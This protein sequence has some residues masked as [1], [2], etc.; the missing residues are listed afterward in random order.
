VLE[1]FLFFCLYSFSCIA[2]YS[3]TLKTF[4]T[5]LSLSLDTHFLVSF[6]TSISPAPDPA[7]YRS[8]EI[9]RFTWSSLF[10]AENHLTTSKGVSGHRAEMEKN[11]SRTQNER[12]LFNSSNIMR[13]S[14]MVL[15]AQNVC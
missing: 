14:G 10:D 7:R 3:T 13:D 8:Q 4:S 11:N 2:S 9:P 1:D 6:A 5:S 12:V 15:V